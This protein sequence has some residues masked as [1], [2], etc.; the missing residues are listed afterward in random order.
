MSW[1]RGC[2]PTTFDW[3]SRALGKLKTKHFYPGE[4]PFEGMG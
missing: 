2:G 4:H 3:T 1:A